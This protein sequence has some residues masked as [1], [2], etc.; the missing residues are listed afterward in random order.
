MRISH[1]LDTS[2]VAYTLTAR[3]TMCLRAANAMR[4]PFATNNPGLCKKPLTKKQYGILF[5]PALVVGAQF[6]IALGL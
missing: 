4:H 1:S 3:G 5:C 6:T 2:A